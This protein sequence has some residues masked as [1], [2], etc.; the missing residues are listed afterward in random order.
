LDSI[1]ATT[2]GLMISQ[3][4]FGTLLKYGKKLL[5]K[6]GIAKLVKVGHR[7][8]GLFTLAVSFLVVMLATGDWFYFATVAVPSTLFVLRLLLQAK[9]KDKKSN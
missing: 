9:N 3:S 2:I 4:L 5:Q 7:F 1:G 8:N 6:V